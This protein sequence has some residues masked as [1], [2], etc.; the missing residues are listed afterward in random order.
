MLRISALAI[1]LLLMLLAASAKDIKFEEE[2]LN[3]LAAQ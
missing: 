1:P 2:E 3:R